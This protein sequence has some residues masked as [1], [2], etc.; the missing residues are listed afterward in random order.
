MII[1]FTVQLLR[2]TFASDTTYIVLKSLLAF[3]VLKADLSHFSC[4]A[5]LAFDVLDPRGLEV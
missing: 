5:L 4:L 1:P 2:R 3:A